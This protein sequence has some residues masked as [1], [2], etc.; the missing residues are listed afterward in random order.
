MVWD[1]TLKQS[2]VG[3]RA[4]STVSCARRRIAAFLRAGLVFL[5]ASWPAVPRPSLNS[6]A[7]PPPTAPLPTF[8]FS[9]TMRRAGSSAQVNKRVGAP[10]S[11]SCILAIPRLV[12]WV[13][14]MP[15]PPRRE[16][17]GP[18]LAAP[19]PGVVLRLASPSLLSPPSTGPC[20]SQAV[21]TC[22]PLSLFSRFQVPLGPCVVKGPSL[23]CIL[24]SLTDIQPCH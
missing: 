10:H 16:P 2:A 13:R 1:F 12:C 11:G 21:A 23:F 18:L 19:R 17:H 9:L 5:M 7:R 22:W 3:P 6:L 15:R 4:Q 20:P 14:R 8:A 24:W